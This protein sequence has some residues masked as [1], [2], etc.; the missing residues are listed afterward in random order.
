VAGSVR[1]VPLNLS[2]QTL[3]SLLTANGGEP[4]L[5]PDFAIIPNGNDRPLK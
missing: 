3:R 1:K 5:E 4:I 2:P